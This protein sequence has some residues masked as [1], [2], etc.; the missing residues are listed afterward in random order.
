MGAIDAWA[1]HAEKAHA[2]K[3][4]AE[5][6]EQGK[7]GLE[8]Y[9]VRLL[10]FD[11]PPGSAKHIPDSTNIAPR[12]IIGAN[13]QG[14]I[15]TLHMPLRDHN[16]V[17]EALVDIAEHVE[18]TRN[19]TSGR[20]TDMENFHRMSLS[21]AVGVVQHRV[22]SS[23]WDWVQGRETPPPMSNSSLCSNLGQD[24]FELRVQLCRAGQRQVMLVVVIGVQRR[25]IVI[26]GAFRAEEVN[27]V[28]DRD[29]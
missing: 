10:L 17:V 18:V 19:S 1:A 28:N 22:W 23:L 14:G 25:V 21:E 3:A 27:W 2:E 29:V 6:G 16:Y 4:H 13:I 20:F 9:N 26:A 5:K 11:R 7:A 24:G 12:R 8:E 15:N